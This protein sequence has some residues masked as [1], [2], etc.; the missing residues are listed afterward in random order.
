MREMLRLDKKNDSQMIF[1]TRFYDDYYLGV[2]Q[3]EKG[4][5]SSS[6]FPSS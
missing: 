3:Y 6:L 2:G 1:R 4:P 5:S